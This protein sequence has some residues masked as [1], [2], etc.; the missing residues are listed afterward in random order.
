MLDKKIFNTCISLRQETH[1]L[2]Y[3]FHDKLPV[4]RSPVSGAWVDALYAL[5]PLGKINIDKI[6][7]NLYL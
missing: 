1:F 4:L 3:A 5:L 6:T 2:C 7:Q